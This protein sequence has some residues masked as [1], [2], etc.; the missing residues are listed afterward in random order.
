MDI[1]TKGDF[2]YHKNQILGQGSFSVIYKGHRISDNMPIA[3]KKIC[4]IISREYLDNEIA[5]MKKLVHPNI[6]KLYGVIYKNDKVYIVMEY[7]NGGD[8][9]KYISKNKNNNDHKFFH[10]IIEGI[11]Y[12]HENNII[13][14]DIKPANF[15]IHDNNIKI[16]DFGFSKIL[17]T[18]E[19]VSTFCGSPL[20]MSPDVLKHN[21]Y[22]Y[23]SDIWSMGVIL[24]ELVTKRHPYYETQA[25]DLMNRVEN[26]HNIDMSY[27]NNDY[28]KKMINL[29]L[30]DNMSSEEFFKF[31]INDI[32][33]KEEIDEITDYR[34]IPL[35]TSV[36]INSFIMSDYIENKLSE[37]DM[38]GT[39][40]PI[41]GSSPPLHSNRGITSVISSSLK[42][43][44]N[45][46]L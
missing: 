38:Y 37:I 26:G 15:L 11:K 2:V 41:Y 20:Y 25:T 13:H 45:F 3:V 14:R 39:S 29:L 32:E 40:M 28:Y 24:Y 43:F 31:I 36:P 10:Q 23:N 9:A 4:K 42:S 17:K 27:I 6:A 18:N 8:L 19:L 46:K 12:L 30:I 5:I 21:K 16:T 22:S 35:S 33:Y 7:C 1:K 44:I 34:D